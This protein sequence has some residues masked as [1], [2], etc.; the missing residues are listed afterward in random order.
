MKKIFF[1]L[2]LVTSPVTLLLLLYVYNDPFKVLYYYESYFTNGEIQR[3]GL[4]ESYISTQNF[5]QNYPAQYYDSY[6]MGGSRSGFYTVSEW[7]KHI[8]STKCY[9]L[10]SN[11]GNL[12][13][14]Q[15]KLKLLD[16]QNVTI[17]NVLITLDTSVFTSNFS[18]PLF[19]QHPAIAHQNIFE[20]Q[21]DFIKYF[22]EYKFLSSYLKFIFTGKISDIDARQHLLNTIEQDYDKET[23]EITLRKTEELIAR[24]RDSFYTPL[25][26]VFK[27]RPSAQQ[28]SPSVITAQ[29]EKQLNSIKQIFTAHNT[30]YKIILC[31]IYN[32]RKM[33]PADLKILQ[34]IF[35]KENV[36][37]FSGIND[38]T[39]DK[40]NYYEESHY[41][42][43]VAN[44]IMD[45]I[46]SKH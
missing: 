31:P 40:Y 27:E 8:N 4:S 6:I 23:N 13:G 36:F 3:V 2:L 18:G 42:T 19:H 14:I 11:G 45:S 37:D 5:L 33:N 21:T 32:Q 7:K 15:N 24:N 22:F 39:E 26:A 12:T 16:S 38:I 17:R 10:N 28:Y 35:G 9:H 30:S 29:H 46:Y 34:Y 41:R 44:R 43:H 25:N 20:F 1:K